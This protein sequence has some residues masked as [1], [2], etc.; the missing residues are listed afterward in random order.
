MVY[1]APVLSFIPPDALRN[2]SVN[3]CR[4]IHNM[5]H[6]AYSYSFL[7]HEKK[8]YTAMAMCDFFILPGAKVTLTEPK[9]HT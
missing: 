8:T 2:I 6:Q 1:P 3:Q 7:L 5:T 9:H 4:I